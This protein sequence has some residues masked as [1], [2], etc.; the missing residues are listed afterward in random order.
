VK[1]ELDRHL[2]QR[3]REAVVL[4]APQLELDSLD[5]RRPDRFSPKTFAVWGAIGG[6]VGALGLLLG[7]VLTQSLSWRWTMFVNLD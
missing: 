7:G 4:G 5:R 3:L 6:G 2:L 1:R